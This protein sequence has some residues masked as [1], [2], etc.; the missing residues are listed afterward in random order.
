MLATAEFICKIN[1]YSALQFLSTDV[2]EISAA[3]SVSSFNSE[4]VKTSKMFAVQPTSKWYYHK[5]K[6]TILSFDY[7]E[8]FK[9]N[10]IIFAGIILFRTMWF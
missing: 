9:A 4:L 6:E 10:R 3:A 1:I 7:K 2:L 5:E 8:S